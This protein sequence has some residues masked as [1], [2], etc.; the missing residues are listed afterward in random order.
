M[1]FGRKLTIA[2]AALGLALGVINII[3]GA[4]EATRD[5]LDRIGSNYWLAYSAIA[6]GVSLVIMVLILFRR[7]ARRIS[8]KV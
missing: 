5:V 1:K 4:N 8:S 6:A 3:F 2:L 7:S